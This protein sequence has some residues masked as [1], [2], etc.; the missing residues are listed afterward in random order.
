[1]NETWRH[2]PIW[3]K[4]WPDQVNYAL[5]VD[6]SGTATIPRREKSLAE[7][8]K[9]SQ[10]F[11]LAGVMIDRNTYFDE[12]KPAMTNLKA[13]FWPPAGFFNYPKGLRRVVLHSREIR[14]QIGPFS[15]TIIDSTDLYQA[16]A[17]MVS[18][19]HF[20]TYAA[21]LNLRNLEGALPTLTLPFKDQ[22]YSLAMHFLLE[23]YAQYLRTRKESGIVV[24]EARGKVDDKAVLNDMIKLLNDKPREFYCIKGIYWVSKWAEW[25]AGKTSFG[26]LELADL[27]VYPVSQW[28]MLS[29][30]NSCI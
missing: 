19:V 2:E 8:R 13:R 25:D 24:L 28:G 6:D 15:G 21:V 1:M 30:Q 4:T 3:L 5:F 16:I 9:H 17:D 7:W 10:Y 11:A 14:R 22:P 12:L 29:A 27:I 23:R 18:S 26:A 20:V